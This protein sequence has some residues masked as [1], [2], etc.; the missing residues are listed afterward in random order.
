MQVQVR[1]EYDGSP[2]EREAQRRAMEERAER[3]EREVRQRSAEPP[4]RA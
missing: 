1:S 4:R 3:Q 2:E